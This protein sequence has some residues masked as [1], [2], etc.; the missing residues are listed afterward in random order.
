M[1]TQHIKNT[2]RGM[3]DENVISPVDTTIT[4]HTLL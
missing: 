2:A 1:N 4:L 3:I